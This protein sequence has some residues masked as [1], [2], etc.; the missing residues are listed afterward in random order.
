MRKAVYIGCKRIDL[1]QYR[2]LMEIMMFDKIP[3][4]TQVIVNDLVAI[5]T[6]WYQWRF[7]RS[8]KVRIRN[9]WAKQGK[10]LR[11]RDVHR[12]IKMGNYLVVSSLTYEKLK[13][14]NN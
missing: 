3:F 5:T 8:K 1:P 6:E 13:D 10:N 11:T 14:I 4:G 7:P 12:V 9:K 2:I